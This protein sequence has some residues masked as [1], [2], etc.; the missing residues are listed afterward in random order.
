MS[1]RGWNRCIIKLIAGRT[2]LIKSQSSTVFGT[3][4]SALSHLFVTDNEAWYSLQHK[5]SLYFHFDL[6]KKCEPIFVLVSN[7]DAFSLSKFAYIQYSI[8]RRDR[9]GE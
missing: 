2:V 7:K 6:N 8:K 1:C 3:P 9:V 5:I 4:S